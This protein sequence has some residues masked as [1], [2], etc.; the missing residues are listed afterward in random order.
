[1]IKKFFIIFSFVALVTNVTTVSGAEEAA[2]Q[3][4]LH[5]ILEAKDNQQRQAT[6]VFKDCVWRE[7]SSFKIPKIIPDKEERKAEKELKKQVS[8]EKKAEKK[9][10]KQASLAEKAAAKAEKKRLKAEW[11]KACAEDSKSKACKEGKPIQKLKK[12][13]IKN[14]N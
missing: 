8:L 13:L 11:K 3:K 7:T 2:T 10:A 9:L 14:K 5:H 4:C 12:L 6:V 1:M